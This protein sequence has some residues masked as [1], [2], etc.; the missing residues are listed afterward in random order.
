MVVLEAWAHK[1]PVLMTPQCNLEIGFEKGAALL[2]EPQSDSIARSL[3]VLFD[4]NTRQLAE[5]GAR[6]KALAESSFS[7]EQV[8]DDMLS[9][10]KWVLGGERPDC[11]LIG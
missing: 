3:D 4:L 9:V 11:V 8:A 1:L 10:Y 6:G 2:M 7:W 5:M